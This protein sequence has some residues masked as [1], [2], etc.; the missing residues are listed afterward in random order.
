MATTVSYF[1]GES[2]TYR[3]SKAHSSTLPALGA[4]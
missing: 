2:L 1:Y 4:V 3:N